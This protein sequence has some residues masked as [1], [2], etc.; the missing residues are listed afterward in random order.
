MER[1]LAC[2][3]FAIVN[4]ART[5]QYPVVH[6]VRFH[7]C[8]SISPVLW[9]LELLIYTLTRDL[10]VAFQSIKHRDYV[11]ITEIMHAKKIWTVRQQ[12]IN[13]TER[14]I[15]SPAVQRSGQSLEIVAIGYQV[16]NL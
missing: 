10:E 9:R 16:T 5:G 8:E 1:L 12:M 2:T 11:T 6:A 4:M 14:E 13:S 15:A 7:I 3:S